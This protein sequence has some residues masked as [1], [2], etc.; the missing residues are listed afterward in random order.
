MMLSDRRV[1]KQAHVGNGGAPGLAPGR[2]IERPTYGE[3]TTMRPSRRGRVDQG[4]YSEE[5][6]M[7]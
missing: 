5:R 6:L 4:R 1:V 2:I 3:R 7:A